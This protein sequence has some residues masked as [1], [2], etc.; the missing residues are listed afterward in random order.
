MKE[1]QASST[2]L[3]VLQG[4]LY[5]ARNPEYA[6]LVDDEL[7]QSCERILNLS[8]QG[9][10]RLKQLDS[11]LV[12]QG[13]LLLE[14][15][16]APGISLHYVLR[17]RGIEDYALTQLKNGINQVIVLGAGL[18]TLA[19]RLSKK[20][21]EVTFIEIDHPAT[22][23]LKA[24][25]FNTAESG[26]SANLHCL[27]IDFSKQTLEQELVQFPVFSAH[28]PT[29]FICE[30]V[31]MYLTEPQVIALFA[32]LKKLCQQR[33]SFVFTALE[34]ENK[35]HNSLLKRYLSSQGE[36]IYW[37]KAK[38]Q[39][40]AFADSQGFMLEDIATDQTLAQRYIKGALPAILHQQEYL[41][42][43]KT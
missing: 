3:T 1:N 15:L 27:A 9:R 14:R 34:P 38:A 4:M 7:R 26:E 11:W 39:L 5:T 16:I 37:F 8:A 10:K 20:Y 18:D 21:P 23:T 17:K 2:A 28:K 31:L 25:F 40:K 35:P 30:G 13:L 29:L 42:F 33:L 24:P 32:S 12:R 22:Q 43:M 6:Y 19:Y 36:A 41:A